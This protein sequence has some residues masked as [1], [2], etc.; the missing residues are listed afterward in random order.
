VGVDCQLENNEENLPMI[1]GMSTATFTLF[2]VVLS[3][4][5]IVAGGVVAV[6][7]L[8]GAKPMPN[9]TLLFLVTTVAT[10]VTGF[11]FHSAFG[12]PHV[13]GI[14]SLV[15]LAIAI[16]ALYVRHLVGAWRWVYVTTALFALYLN[17]FVAVVQAFQK[18]PGLHQLAPQGSEPPFAVAQVLVLALFVWLGIVSVKRLRPSFESAAT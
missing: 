8:L 7:R 2:H 5:G 10:S 11:F 9:W 12:P 13:I 14:I 16:F 18:L 1:L 17:V 15:V 4:I 6:G 3:L